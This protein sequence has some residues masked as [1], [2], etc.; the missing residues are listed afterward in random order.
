MSTTSLDSGGAAAVDGSRRRWAL[1]VKLLISLGLLA[2]IGH[3]VDISTVAALLLDLPLWAGLAAVA[4]MAGVTLA[5]ALR[6]WL[7]LGAIDTPLPLGRAAA[8]MFIGSFF[9]QVLPTSVGG[10]AVRVWQATREGLPLRRAFIGVTLERIS[11]L[12]AVVLM[13]TWGV[14]WLGNVIEPMALRLL[15]LASLPALLAGLAL[16]CLLDRLPAALAGRLRRLPLLGTLLDLLAAMAV[17]SRRVLLSG[18][19]SLNLLLLSAAAQIFSVLT[20]LALAQGFGLAL[21]WAEALAVVPAIIL[22]TFIPLSFAGWGVREG[23]SV[24]LLGFVG[25][26]ADH[27]LA[28]SVLFGLALL[29]ATLPGCLLWLKGGRRLPPATI[30]T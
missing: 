6:W 7:I 24:V 21:T 17:D 18:P 1:A 9:T 11:G 2:V 3:S 30:P 26:G 22:I 14:L 15:L 10:D 8:L 27:A 23:A 12:I 28:I 29:T 4:G 16:L 5:S 20:V 25:V 13:V 19:M